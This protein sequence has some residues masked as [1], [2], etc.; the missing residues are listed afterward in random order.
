MGLFA[1]TFTSTGQNWSSV[2]WPV[3]LPHPRQYLVYSAMRT[4]AHRC[5]PVFSVTW[6]STVLIFQTLDLT[7]SRHFILEIYRFSFCILYVTFNMRMNTRKSQL[8]NCR[9]QGKSMDTVDYEQDGMTST[10]SS[11]RRKRWRFQIRKYVR[12]EVGG[13]IGEKLN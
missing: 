9:S 4:V 11:G 3:N 8:S 12:L 5:E 10:K 1:Y 7:W 13:P 2:I 6:L